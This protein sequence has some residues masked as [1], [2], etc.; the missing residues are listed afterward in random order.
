M[1][2]LIYSVIMVAVFS[3]SACTSSEKPA[4]TSTD[5]ISGSEV[6]A[7]YS[8]PMHPEVKSDKPGTCHICKMDLLKESDMSADGMGVDSVHHDHKH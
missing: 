5:T 1:R 7:V 3:I 4:A 2:K 8:C 6:G